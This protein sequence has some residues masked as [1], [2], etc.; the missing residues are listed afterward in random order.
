ML[1]AARKVLTE[2]GV[3]LHVTDLTHRMIEQ[4]YWQPQGKTPIDS[5]RSALAVDISE[6]GHAS[7]FE[8]VH[9]GIFG[10][11]SS[12]QI[13]ALSVMHPTSVDSAASA[14]P[15]TSSDLVIG[16]MGELLSFADAA[17][18]VL[19]R[20]SK[21]QPLH[22]REI[23]EKALSLGLIT[24]Q[25]KT[26]EATMYAQILVENSRR[27][28]RGEPPRFVQHGKGLISIA[29]RGRLGL[30]DQ[31][32]VHNATT[33][34]R[35]YDHLR[36]MPPTGFESLIGRLL[37]ALGFEQV[38][39]T[40]RSGDGGIDV[41]GTLV[42][43]DVIRTRMAVQVKRWKNNVQAP[44]VQQVRGSLGAH[45]QGLIIT[46]SDYSKGARDGAAQANK[47][48]V[49]LMNGAELVALLVE[50]NIMIRRA[51]HDLIELDIDE[52]ND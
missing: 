42:V 34:K 5:V 47:T 23:T 2:A 13:V 31:I 27:T 25:G 41:Y 18:R 4:G 35:L 15:E 20:D 33:R 21:N 1:D 12:V 11:R 40:N 36:S 10:L 37:G 7:L 16:D 22:Y 19:E 43:G 6:R 9:K 14:Q 17:E 30:A 49:A 50:H 38:Q 28:K 48:P 39:V 44:T 8:R 51:T 24:T 26:P 46:T 52:Q 29:K 45:D 3:P 32:D